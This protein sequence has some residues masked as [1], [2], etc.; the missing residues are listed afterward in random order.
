MTK[1]QRFSDARGRKLPCIDCEDRLPR[2]DRAA[3][4]AH[5]A[6]LPPDVRGNY[7]INACALCGRAELVHKPPPMPEAWSHALARHEADKL[8]VLGP[9]V[10]R[11]G[12][13]K[14]TR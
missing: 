11:L 7:Y 6:A 10:R 9:R 5:F 12:P 4:E 2:Q 1:D 14:R 13:S 3:C 8:A